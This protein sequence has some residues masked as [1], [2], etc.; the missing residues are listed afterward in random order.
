VLQQ[1]RVRELNILLRKGNDQLA[2]LAATD[3]LTGLANRRAFDERLELEWS[4]ACRNKVS[5]ALITL[6]LD[7]FK[8]YNDYFGHPQGDTCLR[9]VSRI[10]AEERRSTDLPA[11]VGG[12][13]FSILLPGADSAGASVIAEKIRSRI[14]ALNLAHPKS[15][16]GVVTASL[17]LAIQVPAADSTP[18]DMV[19][20]ADAALYAAKAAGRNRVVHG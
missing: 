14:E 9:E 8:Q 6:D 13:E 4:R 1:Q 20:A 15:P 12:E 3:A 11:R 2:A 10:M 17:G 7:F 19:E 16:Y 5:L 18:Q